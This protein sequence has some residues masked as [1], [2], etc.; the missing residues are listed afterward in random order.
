MLVELA[1][2]GMTCAA[3]ARRVEKALNR[4]D[5]V[6]AVVNLA[7]HR[8]TVTVA[9]SDRPDS[10]TFVA[11]VERAGYRAQVIPPARPAQAVDSDAPDAAAYRRRRTLTV[12]LPAAVVFTPAVT[13]GFGCT[14]RGKG[15]HGIPAET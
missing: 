12:S 13:A 2:S 15:A 4:L 3:C 1:V 6:A 7:T 14:S 8:A 10:S 5:G 9:G 11:A